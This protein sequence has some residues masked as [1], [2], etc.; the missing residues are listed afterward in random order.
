MTEPKAPAKKKRVNSKAKGSGFE[1]KI[2][3]LLTEKLEPLKFIRSQGSGARVG[4]KN[5]ATAGSMFSQEALTLFVG[6]VVPSNEAEAQQKFRFVVECK[7]YKDAE[8]MEALLAGTSLVYTWI[9]EVLVDCEKVGKE[10]IVIFKFNNT[11][12]Y[13]AVTRAVQLPTPTK[14]TLLNGIQVAFLDDLLEQK[15]F[16]IRT[17][18]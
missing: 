3:K 8:R 1:S 5:F 7:F 15:H 11:K 12:T 18:E 14:I 10:G 16:W 9:N 13:V 4:G 17:Q 6:D 2:A